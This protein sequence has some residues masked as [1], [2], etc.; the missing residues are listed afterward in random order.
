MMISRVEVQFERMLVTENEA[1]FWGGFEG[2]E[3][4]SRQVD[5]PYI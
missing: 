5:K 1:R 3:G 4:S 2:R